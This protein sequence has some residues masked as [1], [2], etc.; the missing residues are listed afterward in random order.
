MLSPTA[1]SR[2]I[3]FACGGREATGE[4]HLRMWLP[5]SL[6]PCNTVVLEILLA[7]LWG[8]DN[9][10]RSLETETIPNF[11]GSRWALAA[12]T[13]FIRVQQLAEGSYP[14]GFLF[15]LLSSPF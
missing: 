9:F 2:G 6:E 3:N 11:R 10:M 5:T 12:V 8:T 13:D 4:R 14:S 7:P 15:L 1:H